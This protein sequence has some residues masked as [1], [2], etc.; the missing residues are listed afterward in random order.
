MNDRVHQGRYKLSYRHGPVVHYA[1]AGVR[2]ATSL[3]DVIT[4]DPACEC[5]PAWR[6]AVLRGPARALVD[7]RMR[8]RTNASWAVEVG[9]LCFKQGE[10]S[11]ADLHIAVYMATLT[12]VLDA[13]RLPHLRLDDERWQVVWG[14]A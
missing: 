5:P 13:S 4:L 7:A 3:R 8:G 10:T 2:A 11:E 6:A 9:A 12:A 1:R 14:L